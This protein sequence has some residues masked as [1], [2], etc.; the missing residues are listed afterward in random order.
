MR[1]VFVLIALTFTVVA[2]GLIAGCNGSHDKM[3]GSNNGNGTSP[4]VLRVYPADGTA[5]G[6]TTASINVKFNMPMDT[7]SVMQAF[8][9]SGGPNMQM[10][11]DSMS[12]QGGMGGM[13]MNR[14]MA[15]MDSIQ[16]HGHLQW[17][18]GGDSCRFIPDS[19]MAPGTDYMLLIYG[20]IKSHDGMM[21]SM[22]SGGM[23]GSNTG[24]EYHF[25]TTP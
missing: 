12:H 4:V 2:I 1:Y 18:Q 23:M 3:M 11:M 5:N 6:P 24:Y 14:M 9:F 7:I 17:N 25:H 13:D 15:L 10:W 8:H 20:L 16:I 21:M 19:T 22:G